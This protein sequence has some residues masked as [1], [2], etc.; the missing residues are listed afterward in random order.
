MARP[1]LARQGE[2]TARQGRVWRGMARLGAAGLGK[3]GQGR[4]KFGAVYLRLSGLDRRT[5]V[6]AA[7]YR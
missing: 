2:D 3:A 4:E 6:R 5:A 1:D 7:V